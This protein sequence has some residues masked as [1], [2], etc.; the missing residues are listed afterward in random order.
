MEITFNS[1]SRKYSEFSNFHPDVSHNTLQYI[2]NEPLLVRGQKTLEHAFQIEKFMRIDRKWADYLLQVSKSKTALEMK[3]L[4]NTGKNGDYF[5]Y[6]KSENDKR[7]K[8]SR[9]TYMALFEE[10]QMKEK[11]L[12]RPFNKGLMKRLLREKFS[13]TN[14]KAAL[15]TTG[16]SSLHEIG[17]GN[18]VWIKSGNDW[19]GKLLQETRR[20]LKEA[21]NEIK[22]RTE[23]EYYEY[24]YETE[25]EEKNV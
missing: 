25:N 15:L 21:S 10:L 11:E 22:E 20:G 17:R 2:V 16:N 12:W 1:R 5:I 3:Q 18:G 23:E 13:N 19:M 9:K 24:M 4:G 7:D 14:Y 8:V 6:V